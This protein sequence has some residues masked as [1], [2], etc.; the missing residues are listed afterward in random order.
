MK[1]KKIVTRRRRRKKSAR[2]MYFGPDTDQAIIDYQKENDLSKKEEIY[3][4]KIRNAFDKLSENLIFIH[5]FAKIHGNY[6]MLKHDCVSFLYETL[7]KY[8]SSRGSK[9]FSYFNV[10]AKNWLIIN[11]KKI[12]KK[13]NKHV[14][15]ENFNIMNQNDK[16]KIETHSIIPS[17]ED[18]LI[19]KEKKDEIIVVLDEIRSRINNKNEIACIEAI[20]TL[21]KKIDDLDFLNKR[22]IFVY[23]R[24]LSSLTPKQLSV[25]MSV[26]RKHYRD[27]KK[28][29]DFLF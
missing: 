9:A 11:S 15:L 27:I 23:M 16:E 28:T 24:D 3:N 21:F 22:A 20:K 4:E 29:G 2:K 25:A 8:D 7:G 6:E 10:V 26:I 1:P 13:R 17:Q 14:S 5:G 19:A 12:T 18:I